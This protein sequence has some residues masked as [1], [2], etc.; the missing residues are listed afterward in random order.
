MVT[1]H[2]PGPGIQTR[3]MIR[4]G[5]AAQHHQQARHG[6]VE[7]EPL[8]GNGLHAGKGEQLPGQIGGAVDRFAD[9][10]QIGKERL[11][12]VCVVQ[13]HLGIPKDDPQHVVEIVGNAAGQPFDRL[14]PFDLSQL[15]FQL[16]PSFLRLFGSG[17]I[18]EDHP[19]QGRSIL[20]MDSNRFQSCPERRA[21]GPQHPQFTCWGAP[22]ASSC[23]RWR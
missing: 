18:A 20:V 17:D 19:I 10:L 21:G 8:G 1:G 6:F 11:V 2:A 13:G 3:S 16:L 23:L 14:H 7:I 22:V 4:A 15:L 9:F 12:R 5:E